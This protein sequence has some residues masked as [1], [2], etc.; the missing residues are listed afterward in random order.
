MK[1][2]D[3]PQHKLE[4]NRSRR[5]YLLRQEGISLAIVLVTIGL[6]AI[7]GLGAMQMN[8]LQEKGAGNARDQNLAFQTAESALR[9][10]EQYVDINLTPT[11]A[12]TAGCTGGLCRPSLTSTPVWQDTGLD[13]WNNS[14]LTFAYSKTVPN[15]IKQPAYIVE[16]VAENIPDIAGVALDIGGAPP[17]KQAAYRITARAWGGTSSAQV[18]LQSVYLK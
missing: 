2:C 16:L 10:A 17:P 3:F 14:S 4:A 5:R 1:H 8:V 7:I 12:F 13:V 15:V 11:S 18:T 6:L 9:D